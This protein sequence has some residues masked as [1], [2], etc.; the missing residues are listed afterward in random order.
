MKSVCKCII[1]L[2]LIASAAG[3]DES[4]S[5]YSPFEYRVRFSDT[6]KFDG[7]NLS[8][9]IIDSFEFE[10]IVH[11]TEY[12]K[13]H[14]RIKLDNWSDLGGGI[15]FGSGVDQRYG[16]NYG[17]VIDKA[18]IKQDPLTRRE[19]RTRWILKFRPV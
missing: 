18:Y 4:T 19:W 15:V 1:L 12:T 6:M 11:W 2:L 9:N 3:A 7:V 17:Q 14:A 13:L 8:G 16:M 5:Q 10:G